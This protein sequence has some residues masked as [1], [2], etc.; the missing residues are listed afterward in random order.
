MQAVCDTEASAEQ[1]F[2]KSL[3]WLGKAGKLLAA[4]RGLHLSLT[5]RRLS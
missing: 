2:R 1:N 3:L 4:K 5:K